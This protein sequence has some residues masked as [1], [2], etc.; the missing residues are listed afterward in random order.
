[1]IYARGR[2]SLN[3][4]VA[5]SRLFTVIILG[6]TWFL[7]RAHNEMSVPYAAQWFAEVVAENGFVKPDCGELMYTDSGN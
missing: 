5:S 6:H 1:M 2:N 3:E 4:E 7:D